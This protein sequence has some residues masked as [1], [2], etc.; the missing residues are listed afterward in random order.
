MGY[1]D[2]DDVAL[3]KLARE[4]VMNIRNYR[5]IFADYGIDE[6]DFYQIEKNEFFVKVK[7]QF[8]REWNSVGSTKD[9]VQV[10]SLAY[11][12]QLLPV[13]TRRALRDDTNLAVANDVGKLLMKSAGMERGEGDKADAERFVIQ[14]NMGADVETFDKPIAIGI[15]DGGSN[16][17]AD[18]KTASRT[19]LK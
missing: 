18:G 11:F 14:I 1:R 5:E 19:S 3:A 8:A 10:G 15:E 9:R 2:L 7:E 4:L 16:G 6:T 13:L 12:E 17:K